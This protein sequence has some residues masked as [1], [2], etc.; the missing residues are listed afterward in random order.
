VKSYN[1]ND[2]IALKRP[3]M[4]GQC[5]S[6]YTAKFME[7]LPIE[8]CVMTT[9][10]KPI[11]TAATCQS[12]SFPSFGGLVID[13]GDG[14]NFLVPIVENQ[15]KFSLTDFTQMTAPNSTIPLPS[16]FDAGTC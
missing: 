8:G 2:K 6:Q 15:M 4:F 14:V 13:S 12:L 10:Q 1:Q 7:N 3:G 9:S 16:I 11:M 5:Q